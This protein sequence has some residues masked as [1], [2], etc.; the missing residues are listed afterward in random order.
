MNRTNII[1]KFKRCLL[2]EN[3][4]DFK[5]NPYKFLKKKINLKQLFDNK[6]NSSYD[7]NNL[8]KFNDSI[9]YY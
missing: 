2:K 6:E 8:N 7:N 4:Y 9:E 1:N 3:Y 5:Y